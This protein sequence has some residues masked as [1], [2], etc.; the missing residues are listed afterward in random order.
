MKNLSDFL[1]EKYFKS[2]KV[3]KKYWLDLYL[4]AYFKEQKQK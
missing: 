4:K 2:E 3:R 1:R